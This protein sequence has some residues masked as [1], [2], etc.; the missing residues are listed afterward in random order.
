MAYWVFINLNSQTDSLD[1]PI[2]NPNTLV[3]CTIGTT[4][5]KVNVRKLNASNWQLSIRFSANFM[6]VQNACSEKMSRYQKYSTKINEPSYCDGVFQI[7][8]DPQRRFSKFMKRP[9]MGEEKPEY[10]P[11]VRVLL[12]RPC[13]R[14]VLSNGC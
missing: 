8:R 4:G 5:T 13:T 3:S 10:Y 9:D 14:K 2:D 11:D 12:M 6:T 1:I 7:I